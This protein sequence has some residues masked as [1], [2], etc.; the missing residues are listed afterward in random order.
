MLE[1]PLKKLH[2][3]NYVI[4]A[5][6]FFT[7]LFLTRN[8]IGMTLTKKVSPAFTGTYRTATGKIPELK[9]IMSYAPIVEKNPFGRPMKFYPISTHN[10]VNSQSPMSELILVGTVTGP[11]DL[12]Y[13]IFSDKLRSSPARQEVF[14][15]GREVYN[16]GTLTR[17]ENNFVE[18]S[19]GGK[20][21]TIY[22]IDISDIKANNSGA[23][24]SFLSRSKLVKKINDKQY[25]LDQRKVQQALN[26]PK[27]ILSD[28]RLYPNMKNGQ[29]EGF[30]ILEVKPG[31][32]YEDLGLRNRD[33]LL[34]IN[35]LELSS[36][37]AAMQTLTA[38]KG[39]NTVNLDII[40]NGT[41]MTLGYQIR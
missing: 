16:Y 23:R 31:G 26:D 6:V 2:M 28:A 36:P 9:N 27:R 17:I 1:F 37:E 20:I 15:F 11:E 14:A 19:K 12:S 33:I 39:M 4:I 29:Q 21:N 35:G 24:S 40:R 10:T 13:A 18:L 38:L 5:L 41:N 34:K 3:L 30:T 8:I 7:L 32:I 22:L 25:L